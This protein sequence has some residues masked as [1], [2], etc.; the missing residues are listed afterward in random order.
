MTTHVSDILTAYGLD[1]EKLKDVQEK[2]LLFNQLEGDS[3]VLGIDNFQKDIHEKT[4]YIVVVSNYSIIE[5]RLVQ[6]N[7]NTILEKGKNEKMQKY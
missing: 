4:K 5:N 6:E 7:I 1:A 3:A 2:Q